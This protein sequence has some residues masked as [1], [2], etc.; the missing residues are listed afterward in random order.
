M[1]TLIMEGGANLRYIQQMLGHADLSSTEIHTA[2]HP[3]A[4]LER[5][6]SAVID[7]DNGRGDDE[8]KAALEAESTK[9]NDSIIAPIRLHKVMRSAMMETAHLH[10]QSWRIR[11]RVSA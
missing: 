1:A 3:G 2:T 7:D 4:K 8:Q 10:S 6:P 5:K 11:W 9:R